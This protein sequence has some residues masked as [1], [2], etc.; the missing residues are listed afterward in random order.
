MSTDWEEKFKQWA[1]A[2][3][4]TEQ[5]KA[6]NAEVAVRKSIDISSVLKQKSI[7]VFPQGSYRNK[8]NIS[9][10]SDVDI[11]VLCSDTFYFD[12]PEG[13]SRTGFGI[14]PAE[15][16]YSIYKDDV[17]SAL[18]SHFGREAVTR[19]RK[20]FDIH[21]NSNRIDADVIPCFEYR[22]YNNDGTFTEGTAFI[23]DNG[24]RVINWPEQ[25]YENGKKKND[26]TKRGFKAGVRILKNLKHEM[27]EEGHN[28]AKAIPS[29]LCEC[30]AWNVPD[31]GF[32][33]GDYTADVRYMLMHLFNNTIKFEDCKEWG[34][35]NELKYLFRTSQAWTLKE[36]HDFISSAWDYIGF[37]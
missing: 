9:S 13:S 17:E 25:N 2:P 29:F 1:K 35:I 28:E 11:C 18:V 7:R 31:E 37:G 8:T 20:A 16:E 27:E 6:N 14:T 26:D 5:D 36:T 22:R 10:E 3:S 30:L 21:E 32:L 4:Q 23:P 12:L 34:E 24:G 15:Y 19:G 33:H